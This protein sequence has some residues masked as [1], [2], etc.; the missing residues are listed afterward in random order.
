MQRSLHPYRVP[1]AELR[2]RM[3][4]P[5]NPGLGIRLPI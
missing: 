2:P 5:S 1:L 3:R 4:T